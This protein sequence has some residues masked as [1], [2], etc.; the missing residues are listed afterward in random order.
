MKQ[1]YQKSI[2]C[3]LCL[4]MGCSPASSL[5]AN[6]Y[7]EHAIF[8]ELD[9]NTTIYAKQ[10]TTPVSPASLTKIMSAIIAIEYYQDYFHRLFI[11][12]TVLNSL[13]LENSSL[14]GFNAY[15]TVTVKDLLY[16]TL[17][18]SGGEAT[19]TLAIDIA[20]SEEQFVVLMNQLAKKLELSNTHFI[21]ACGFDDK[22]HYST[23]S[24]IGKLLIYCLKNDVFREIF[25]TKQY[26]TSASI[27]HP[28]GITL[29]ST[30]FERMPSSLTNGELFILV[31]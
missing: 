13:S 1:I 19:L 30:M 22:N 25:T 23:V 10:E 3:F 29:S 31:I 26:T 16:G 15:E 2:L 5:D 20:G 14:A 12:P 4:L 28:N 9:T 24:D 18:S 7:S 21:N 27:F 17:L 8:I 11:S 6:L